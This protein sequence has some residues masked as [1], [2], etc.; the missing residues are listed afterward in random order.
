MTIEEAFLILG[1]DIAC[2]VPNLNEVRHAFF[3]RAR[4]NHPDKNSETDS[5]IKVKR[6]EVFKSLL[7]AYKKAMEY[8]FNED[9]D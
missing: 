2:Q 5:G 6:E 1:L 7:E 3:E 4:L 8:K 9:D